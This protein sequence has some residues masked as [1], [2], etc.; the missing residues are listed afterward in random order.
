M[1]H[2][3][4]L[5][6]LGILTLAI[7][8][9]GCPNSSEKQRFCFEDGVCIEPD[10]SR[11]LADGRPVCE[12]DG[13]CE[14]PATPTPSDPTLPPL[15]E[16]GP[17]GVECD[18]EPSSLDGDGDCI[19]D[20]LERSG[21]G[22]DPTLWD[23]DGDEVG[24]GCE[25]INHNGT[26]DQVDGRPVESDP[27]NSDSDDDGLPD[28]IED[29]DHDG[30][31]GASET[32][33]IR[34]DSDGDGID[35]G[36]ED[37][38]QNG[39]VEPWEDVD[40]DGCFT[41][42]VDS[43][44]EMNPRLL[45]S[46]VDGIADHA[47]DSNGDGQWS[48][49]ET[50]PWL[51]DTDCDGLGD[52]QEDVNR[53]GYLN[54]HETD[55]TMADTDGDG[56]LD[57]IE[58]ANHNGI[59]EPGVETHP[60]R[61]DTDGDEIP[62][63][64]EDRD[65]DGVVDRFVDANGN[66]CWDQG[67]QAGESDPRLVD[68]DADG[69]EDALEDSNRDGEC[70]W[71]LR[72]D[73][74]APGQRQVLVESCAFLPDSDCDGLADGQEDLNRNGQRDLGELD[75][76]REDTDRDGLADGCGGRAQVP[77]CEDANNDGVFDPET[78]TNPLVSDT[79]GD[80][81]VDG[82]EARFGGCDA[83]D[84]GTNP[85]L[86]DSDGDGFSDGEEDLNKNCRY[87]PGGVFGVTDPRVADS[88]P[89]AGGVEWSRW[90]VCGQQNQRPVSQVTSSRPTHDYRLALDVEQVWSGQQCPGGEDSEC[91]NGDV[92]SIRCVDMR[93]VVDVPYLV[94]AFGEDTNG[95]GFNPNDVADELWGHL[96]QSPRRSV[97]EPA[98][99]RILNSDV[100]GFVLMRESR[101]SLDD[102]LDQFRNS[103]RSSYGEVEEVGVL[104]A[105]PAHD[106]LSAAPVLM[107]QRQLRVQL[108][109]G[110]S[111][112]AFRNELLVERFLNGVLPQPD[113]VPPVVDPVYGNIVC[114][115]SFRCYRQFTVY[116]NL[117]KRVNQVGSGGEPALI[118]TVALTPNDSSLS[119]EAFR[120]Y[121]DRLLTLEDI[122][123]GSSLAR[124]DAEL[125]STCETHEKTSAAADILWVVDDSRSMQQMIGRL[126]S[127][128]EQAQALLQSNAGI[129][130]FRLALTTTNAASGA[131]TRC[132]EGC[133]AMCQPT[134]A[135]FNSTCR[136]W[137]ADQSV[138]CLSAGVDAEGDL[139]QH[140]LPGGG[141]TFYYE[142]N[143]YLDCDSRTDGQHRYMNSCDGEPGFDAFFGGERVLSAHAGFH[144]SDLNA[145]CSSAPMDLSYRIVEGEVACANQ[146]EC[147][148]ER[149]TQS[150][151][152]GPAILVS[153]M[154]DL[155]R[156]MGGLPSSVEESNGARPHSAPEHG[157]RSARRLLE[158]MLP[159]LPYD[160]SGTEYEPG[161]HLRLSCS[162]S[163]CGP[164]SPGVGECPV[165][166]LLTVF[167]S[168]EEDF[169]FKDDC[170]RNAESAD[171]TQLPELCYWV[172]G[173]PA[174]QEPC[175][176]AYCDGEGFLTAPPAGYAPDSY[177]TS[178]EVNFS[179]QWRNAEAPECS[180]NAA[181]RYTTCVADPCTGITGVNAQQRCLDWN[182]GDGDV[183]RWTNGVCENICAQH[184]S[185]NSCAANARC[186]W[187]QAYDEGMAQIKPCLLATP[188]NDCRACKR[189][190]RMNESLQ[191]D[192]ELSAGFEDLGTVYAIVRDKGAQG[193][194]ELG[195]LV[196]D[197][198]KGG[199]ISWGRGDGQAYRDL[200]IN[201]YG[202]TQNICAPSYLDFMHNLTSDIAVMSVPYG[203]EKAPL[204]ATIRVGIARPR[205]EGGY[206]L[207][208][209]P[210]SRTQGFFYSASTRSIGFKSDPVDGACGDGDCTEDG[211]IEP[212]EILFAQ[213]AE[214]VPRTGDRLFVT[215][216]SWRPLPCADACA[217]D[218]TCVRASCQSCED[219]GSCVGLAAE[220]PAGYTCEGGNC[221]Q[222]CQ[223]GELIDVCV[224]D[225]RCGS[226]ATLNG[227]GECVPLAD[228]CVC[229]PED[230][231][232][233]APEGVNT[234]P[235]GFSC[236]ESCGCDAIPTCDGGFELSGEVPACAP[237]HACCEQWEGDAQGC[238][239]Y[240]SEQLC[241]GD[242]D[243][244]VDAG[245]TCGYV[246]ETC[247]QPGE[248]LQ[249]IE[250][251]EGS[252]FEVYCAPTCICEPG[253]E[254]DEYCNV[255]LGCLC[256]KNSP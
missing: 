147:Y 182:T 220:C 28:G 57:G 12:R 46:D 245:G 5:R 115:T 194:G 58:D 47:E 99:T 38:N 174:T 212:A 247:C 61:L 188:I 87:E 60:L 230:T 6:I 80:G 177:A 156:S 100:Y 108:E 94:Q 4:T 130:D 256:M 53:N 14:G 223:P 83:S 242:A 124:F 49:G 185:E 175:T 76:L 197:E 210:R 66:G 36:E 90:S 152:D 85:R 151:T 193:F 211:V 196:Q 186:R 206:G 214:H 157:I 98:D 110:R 42:G 136:D 225:S 203:L 146:E 249:C 132:A 213:S 200:A 1:N 54:S 168:D 77:F 248:T 25:D 3:A 227:E 164:C 104:T 102:A 15:P 224:P 34:R 201:T 142:D 215:Y 231:V 70:L 117:V 21:G 217:V 137:C 93:C 50:S 24:D 154:C 39:V 198:C 43:P 167:L 10:G 51:S 86:G 233:C 40:G 125:S 19:P 121:D 48:V 95:N 11:V 78:E 35:D 127:A 216:Q 135:A 143:L 107:A 106:D 22:S 82:C 166:P 207:I 202:R 23:T 59:W 112:L 139:L 131:R 218:E 236:S 129:V 181:F 105:R 44:G 251:A 103:L 111:A 56:L 170:E 122:T 7:Y 119:H 31:R 189:L 118:Y 254:L 148:C 17:Q 171:L 63:G 116:I 176:E 163:E 65:H 13:S 187:E 138:G 91:T 161:K 169:W 184:A 134:D 37:Q 195:S 165:V 199:P 208:E 2:S 123:G 222:T 246:Y 160:Y 158:R 68:S 235:M 239:D 234:C 229:P 41:P 71:A 32:S 133:D 27:R 180:N 243:C 72:S 209:V 67:E 64:V 190:R 109:Q 26:L 9:A 75:P 144:G 69:L 253:C 120:L 97:Q 172:D 159:A 153:Q 149:L 96:F 250:A 238:Y 20:D 101:Q 219:A 221:E 8:G 155:I 244:Y 52:G 228:P 79:D 113:D 240:A 232:M 255:E 92:D 252:G 141:G 192:P 226:C 145:S 114:A 126:E 89:S 16:P 73:A 150:C 162:E 241:E 191:G 183:C 18:C 84:C 45:D 140:R 62:D 55:P 173:D 81:L 179:Q 33:P 237:A 178:D 74:L 204:G 88:A 205:S 29:A 128:A 30:S